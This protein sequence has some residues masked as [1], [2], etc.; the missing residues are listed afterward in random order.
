M[1][2]LNSGSVKLA[3]AKVIVP[4]VASSN[5][6][7]PVPASQAESVEALVQEPLTVHA[8]LPKSMADEADEMSTSPD[9]DTVPL[10]EVRSPPDIASDVLVLDKV[11]ACVLLASVPPEMVRDTAVSCVPC[12]LV[13]PETVSVAKVEP[14]EMLTEPVPEKVTDELVAVKLPELMEEVSQ[15][16]VLM[17][18]VDEAKVI[19]AAPEEVRLLAPNATVPALVKVSVP[20]NVRLLPIVVLMAELTVRLLAVSSM[21]MVPLDTFT[22]MVDVPGV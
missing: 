20:E 19:T 5:V 22:T 2:E 1:T 10:V 6:T 15:L 14:E 21:L 17:V 8:S 4:A 7:E 11:R 3:P 9:M 18:I 12:V 16:P 13:P